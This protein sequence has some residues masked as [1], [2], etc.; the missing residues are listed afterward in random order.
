MRL[1][2]DFKTFMKNKGLDNFIEKTASF[3][4]IPKDRLMV[5]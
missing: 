3:L 2:T 5:T 1:K 4:K